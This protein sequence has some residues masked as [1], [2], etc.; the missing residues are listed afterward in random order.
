MFD[1]ATESKVNQLIIILGG[2][3]TDRI[4]AVKNERFKAVEWKKKS[5]ISR[6]V[7]TSATFF[8]L[9]AVFGMQNVF[10]VNDPL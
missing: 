7:C 8:N 5:K 4:F 1:Y 2:I 10:Y 9:S 3:H 6:Y